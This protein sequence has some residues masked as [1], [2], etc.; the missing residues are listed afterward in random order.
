M[1]CARKTLSN[2]WVPIFLSVQYVDSVVTIFLVSEDN[3]GTGFHSCHSVP[4]T[5]FEHS[6]PQTK[7]WSPF[8]NISYAQYSEAIS[9]FAEDKFQREGVELITNA[10]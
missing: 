5:Y 1:I 10:R 2:T 4:R 6:A 9:K 7:T 8:S 3:S